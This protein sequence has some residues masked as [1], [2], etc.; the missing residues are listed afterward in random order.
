MGGGG[1]GGLTVVLASGEDQVTVYCRNS[2]VWGQLFIDFKNLQERH[3]YVHWYDQ[4]HI[5]VE[6]FL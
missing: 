3:C 5:L 1:G 4:C 2:R 6:L